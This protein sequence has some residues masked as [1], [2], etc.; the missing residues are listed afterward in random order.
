MELRNAVVA[1]AQEHEV[2]L[3]DLVQELI[4]DLLAFLLA[5]LAD[6]VGELQPKAEIGL[7]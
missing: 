6:A 2:D 4:V 5:F 7:D 3:P 1:I